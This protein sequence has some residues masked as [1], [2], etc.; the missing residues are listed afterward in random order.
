MDQVSSKV[1]V[2]QPYDSLFFGGG[3]GVPLRGDSRSLI[4]PI[5]LTVS[6]SILSLLME[7]KG[8]DHVLTRKAMEGSNLEELEEKGMALRYA[9]YGPLILYRG[10][11]WVP[12]PRDL[13]I[14]WA[15]RGDMELEVIPQNAEPGGNEN[16][17]EPPLLGPSDLYLYDHFDF[18]IAPLKELTSSYLYGNTMVVRNMPRIYTESRLGIALDR[19]K[20]AV[21]MGFLYR[22]THIRGQ[23]SRHG[24]MSYAMIS[25]PLDG[26]EKISD[27]SG[28]TRLGGEG[29]PAL[30]TTENLSLRWL[31]ADRRLNEGDEIK[32]ILVSPAIY[33]NS[34]GTTTNVPDVSELPGRPE[35]IPPKVIS[36]RPLMISGWNLRLKRARRMYSAVP[37]GTVYRMKV[38]ESVRMWDMMISFWKLSLYWDRGMG[39]PLLLKVPSGR[40]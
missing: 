36:S 23:E 32:V 13:I 6:G 31:G 38:R 34:N 1:V 29:R 11:F 18:P 7:K 20:G 5:P 8:K 39:S 17:L 21:K 26:R 40:R 27:L 22:T 24:R 12:A 14:N 3:I 37:P 2:V 4:H 9:L 33:L 35:F 30:I 25:I 15:K 19:S 28:V 10:E 16:G